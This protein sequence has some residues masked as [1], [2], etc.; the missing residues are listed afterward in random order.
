M[1]QMKKKT[2]LEKISLITHANLNAKVKIVRIKKLL[3]E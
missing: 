3:R 2:I 1:K